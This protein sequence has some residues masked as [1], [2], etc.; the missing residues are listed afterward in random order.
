MNKAGLFTIGFTRK[1]A[2]DFF[3]L[4]EEN[5]VKKIIDIRLNNVS[6]LAG[7]AKKDDLMFFLR[8][9]TIVI[10]ITA[11]TGPPQRIFWTLTRKRRCS[12]LNSKSL[13]ELFWKA[14]KLNP[15][16]IWMI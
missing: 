2:E 6:Q 7:F 15:E 12:G 13:S 3:A 14:G 10:M 16:P 8:K 1:K 9:L 5:H 11:L 4:L